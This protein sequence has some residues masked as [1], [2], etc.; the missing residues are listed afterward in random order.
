M[1]RDKY[2][3]RKILLRTDAQRELAATVLR[4]AP[5]DADHPLEFLMREEVKARKLDQN[6]L[7]W[8]GPLADIAEH[9]YVD[10]RR[11]ADVVWHEFFKREFLPEEFDAELCKE[12]YRKWDMDPKGR[13][14]LVGSTTQLTVKGFALYLTQVEA[15]GAGELG[16]KFHANPREQ[17]AA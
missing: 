6:S 1:K 10:G 16:V 17:R 5:L 13:R 4:N 12:G 9:G 7:M 14:V 15:Y 11:Y 3:T 2:P 8:V